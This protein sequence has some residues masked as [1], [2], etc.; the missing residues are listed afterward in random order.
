MSDSDH[1]LGPAEADAEAVASAE[2]VQQ[3]YAALAPELLEA[4][5]VEAT[6]EPIA[7]PRLDRQVVH[8]V[9]VAHD[10]T[11]WLPRT[12][13]ALSRVD[14][15]M[16]TVTAVDT[17]ST[18]E[19]ARLL[20]QAPVVSSVLTRAG[21]TGFPHAVNDA[22]SHLAASLPTASGEA[23]WL[24]LLHD[25]VAAR[26][27][28]LRWL[29][30]AAIEHDAAVVGPKVLDWNGR[31]LL[32]ELG[33]SITG[34]GRRY[35]G[36][37]GRE[38][39]QG[40]HDDRR[41]VLAVGTAGMLV[42]RD[43]W[44]ALGGLDPA[45][46]L[47]RDD[48]DFGWRARLSGRRV[49]V[50]PRAVVEH[51]ASA[52]TGRRRLAATS[53][54]GPLTDRRN[55]VHVM[56]ANASRWAFLPV[57]LRV[58]AGS[59]LRSIGF[60]IGKVPGVAWDEAVAVTAALHPGRL[61]RARRWRAGA[62]R[63]ASVR[64]LR[65][66][67]GTQIRHALDN[68]TAVVSGRSGGQ[69]VPAARR[70]LAPDEPLVGDEHEALP[71]SDGWLARASGRP[72]VWL[73][74]GV[75]LLT[76]L[77]ARTLLLGGQLAGGALLPAPES[78]GDW[79]TSY[80]ASWH[81]VGL[82]SGEGA[83]PWLA[84]LSAMSVPLLGSAS[85]LVAGLLLAAV[86]LATASA[87]WAL[88]GLATSLPLRLWAAGTYGVLLLSTGAV[89]A[90]RLG[91]CV[92]AVLAPF[93]LR[94][95]GTALRP[96]APL[97]HSWR[98]ALLLAVVTA[99]TPVVWPVTVAAALATT[100]VLA[101]SAA[102]LARWL[103]VSVVPALLLAPWLP[104]LQARPELL[105]GEVGLTGRGGELSQVS[106]PAWSP[107]VLSPGGPGSLPAGLLA[108]IPVVALLG[109]ALSRSVHVGLAW[110]LAVAAMAA[111]VTTSRVGVSTPLG[112]G[113]AAGWPGPAVVVVGL[114][115]L[116][117]TAVGVDLRALREQSRP[118]AAV[119]VA[120]ALVTT[121]GVAG[122]GFASA[123]TDPLGRLD[124]VLLPAYVAEEAAGPDQV[125][126]L[127]LRPE[128]AD[129]SG[130][131]EFTV[132]RAGAA[133]LGDAAVVDPAGSDLLAPVVADV[134]AGRGSVSAARLATFG[135]RY[136]FVPGA[137]APSVIETLDGQAGLVR[138]SAPD[139]GAIWRVDGTTAR[140]R[141][142]EPD[143]SGEAAVGVAVPSAETDVSAVIST[144]SADRVVVADLDDPG[145]SA[146]LDGEALVKRAY[147]G[148]LVSFELPRGTGD[149]Q[150][151]HDDPVRPWLLV[152]QAGAL[153][154][155]LVL[156]VPSL[157]GRR[158]SLEE[159]LL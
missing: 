131:L 117:A 64:G 108:I 55:A 100:L 151:V 152:G 135:I 87:Y 32:V 73:V 57:L 111:A 150:I 132:V 149:L 97:R 8:V 83:P 9:L 93:L 101:R 142:L 46:D 31:R 12:L 50:E 112:E 106:L 125:R 148:G 44:E 20:G 118:L 4:E 146:T 137:A 78:A 110:L 61:R 159:S 75:A 25:D 42:R 43:A 84:A 18:D 119:V 94:A 126:T 6:D 58:V 90:G 3:I 67:L 82:G 114:A 38:F 144:E 86:P 26:P 21:T 127:V 121:L 15:P 53:Q 71:V 56:L 48:V 92:T 91:T 158:E 123:T 27:D 37:E 2:S 95:V 24:W 89:A 33:L 40:Q 145:W 5:T 59:V 103:I 133:A 68:A 153:V 72:G 105:V 70:R 17:G 60:V 51:A 134:V 140:V 104:T 141:L 116:L 107:V 47:F 88:R 16:A 136:V 13:E 52:S 128:A 65:P 69:D 14:G 113:T 147:A 102:G 34:S 63:V 19:T 98:A 120:G 54:R 80:L 138:A 130:T 11:R 157:G 155:V 28:T 49:V 122:L 66:T 115:L 99:V 76:L 45:I 30:H 143:D 62:P 36:L 35:T 154:V 79:W 22:V 1:P 109:L 7:D 139:G 156:M 39:D 81:P 77:S 96:G 10:G 29:L 74:G 41:D 129:G 85:A 124:S 23:E